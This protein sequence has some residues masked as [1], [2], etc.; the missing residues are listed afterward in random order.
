MNKVLS[1]LSIII[2]VSTLGCV[3][4]SEEGQINRIVKWTQPIF[5]GNSGISDNGSYVTINGTFELNPPVYDDLQINVSTARSPASLAP[6][7][8]PYKGSQVPAF[9]DSQVNVIYFTAQLPH[10]Y[11]EG[12]NLEFH[13]HVAYPDNTWGKSRWYMTYSWA[14]IGDTFPVA[15]SA[16]KIQTSMNTT[17]YHQLI[18]LTS[19]IN[20]TGKE[21]S[22]ILLCSIQRTGTALEDDYGNVI[23]LV[24]ADFHYQKDTLGSKTEHAK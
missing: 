19:T 22:S 20:G 10:G 2:L 18:S 17:D 7:W 6:T 15:L 14:N 11:K 5:L 1:F 8:T 23:Y 9:S 12:S 16:D 3:N 21:I 4:I 13:I 24:G